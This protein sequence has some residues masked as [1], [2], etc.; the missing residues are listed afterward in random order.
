MFFPKNRRTIPQFSAEQ[1]KTKQMELK[2]LKPDVQYLIILV[3]VCTYFPLFHLNAE[4][5]VELQMLL[6]GKPHIPSGYSMSYCTCHLPLYYL[7][8]CTLKRNSLILSIL[9]FTGSN[10]LAAISFKV[11]FNF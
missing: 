6:A 1:F 7:H 4:N 2:H 8:V 11:L 5:T 3:Q 10:K 9:K